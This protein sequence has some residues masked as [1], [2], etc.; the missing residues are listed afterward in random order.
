MTNSVAE[1]I[2]KCA[3]ATAIAWAVESLCEPIS[4]ESLRF[5][6]ELTDLPPV[7]YDTYAEAVRDGLEDVQC[8]GT[9]WY[10]DHSYDYRPCLFC[11]DQNAEM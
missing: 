10:S 3:A 7:V 4:D 8:D 1:Y 9:G 2:A 5:E 6:F 11:G